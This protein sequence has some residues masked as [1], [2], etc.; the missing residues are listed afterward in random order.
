MDN[1]KKSIKMSVDEKEQWDKLYHYVK[2]E[3]LQYDS[4]QSIPPNLILRLKGLKNGKLIANRS[5]ENKAEYTFDIILYTF[6]LC[7]TQIFSG[8]FG[9][10]FKDEMTKFIY[11]TTIVENNINDVYLRITNAK[12]LQEK[13]EIINVDNIYNS[14]ADYQKKTV[15]NN[16]NENLNNLW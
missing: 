7:K 16:V 11:I 4:N 3:I 1:K 10:V 14:G 15:D 13:T 8:I 12:K 5:T 6:K 9:K 2:T